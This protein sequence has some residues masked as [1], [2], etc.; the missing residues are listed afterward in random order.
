[1]KAPKT[2]NV[3]IKSDDEDYDDA[4]EQDTE[5]NEQPDINNANSGLMR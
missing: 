5:A 1:M 3:V 2:R 4:D